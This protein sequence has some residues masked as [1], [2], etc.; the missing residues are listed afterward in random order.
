MRGIALAGPVVITR[1]ANRAR[2][3]APVAVV[4]TELC[5]PTCRAACASAPLLVGA[6]QRLGLPVLAG[7]VAVNATGQGDAVAIVQYRRVGI[8]A[9]LDLPLAVLGYESAELADRVCAVAAVWRAASRPRTVLL[10][11]PRPLWAA[12]D[13]GWRRGLAVVN[14]A[15]PAPATAH[16]EARWPVGTGN[17]VGGPDATARSDALRLVA[18][19]SDVVLVVGS[20]DSASSERVVEQCRHWGTP[21]YQIDDAGQIE[22][23]WLIDVGTVGLTAGAPTAPERIEGIITAL[24]GLGPVTVDTRTAGGTEPVAQS[25]ATGTASPPR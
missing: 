15:Y 13:Y 25:W 22:L 6:F 3:A 9:E 12:E 7:P 14:S 20:A 4:A 21:A 24:G 8:E 10:A 18:A 11:D 19:E 16:D 1:S 23:E 2:G 5:W 17:P